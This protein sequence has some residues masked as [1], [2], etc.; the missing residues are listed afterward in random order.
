MEKKA[1]P[2]DPNYP[3]TPVASGQITTSGDTIEIVLVQP[4][5]CPSVI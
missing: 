2:R 1:Q 5:D 3:T 4:A